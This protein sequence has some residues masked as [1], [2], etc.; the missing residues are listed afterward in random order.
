MKLT[1][2]PQPCVRSPAEFCA[3]P[4]SHLVG[5][6]WLPNQAPRAV[7]HAGPSRCPSEQSSPE[8]CA[9]SPLRVCPPN[10]LQGP[11]P[12]RRTQKPENP[13][14]RCISQPHLRVRRMASCRFCSDRRWYSMGAHCSTE[15]NQRGGGLAVGALGKQGA[16]FGQCQVRQAA[17]DAGTEPSP[18]PSSPLPGCL[19]SLPL[20]TR[21][22]LAR[23]AGRP[24]RAAVPLSA[25]PPSAAGLRAP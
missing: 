18:G 11:Y 6:A 19:L 3:L 2:A 23:Q 7:R 14:P 24:A 15:K 1:Q 5:P 12:R 20:S 8:L 16:A 17:P 22:P 25:N 9:P 10:L 4:A 21:P 13:L